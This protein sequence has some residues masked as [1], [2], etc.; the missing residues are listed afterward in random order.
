MSAAQLSSDLCQPFLNHLYSSVF[1]NSNGGYK[2][3][4]VAAS[5]GTGKDGYG[6]PLLA[7]HNGVSISRFVMIF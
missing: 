3:T 2:T 6:I 5:F 4:C 1:R 7:G